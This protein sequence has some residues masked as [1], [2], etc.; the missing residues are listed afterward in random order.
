MPPASTSS[1]CWPLNPRGAKFAGQCWRRQVGFLFP[2]RFRS[3]VQPSP[4]HNPPIG[5]PY[6]A[7]TLALSDS[8]LG[9]AMLE[10]L[11][12]ADRYRKEANRYADLAKDRTQPRFLNDLFR[13]TAVRY[14]LMAEDLE[15][16][17]EPRHVDQGGLSASLKAR[18]DVFLMEGSLR[19]ASK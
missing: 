8:L 15:R 1:A 4:R 2:C 3:Y 10:R 12:R 19:R 9:R 11:S 14:V 5:A 17:P 18:A 6:S 16:S 13:Q 7:A